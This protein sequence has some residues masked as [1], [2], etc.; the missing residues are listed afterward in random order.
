[1]ASQLVPILTNEATAARRQVYFDLRDATDGIT[2]ETGEAGGQPQISTNGGAWTNTGIGTLTSIGSG[3]YYAEVTQS[4]T[5]ITAGGRIKTR[6][7][8]ANTAE[9]RGDTLL[10]MGADPFLATIAANVTQWLGSAPNALVSGRVDSSTG[11]MA[12]G[13]VTA[14]A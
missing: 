1:M 7:K 5:N 13:V 14:A 2:A 6:Y 3:E 4:A 10:I 8:S 9:S 12:A 11:A